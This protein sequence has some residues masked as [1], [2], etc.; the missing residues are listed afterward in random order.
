M[1]TDP[2]GARPSGEIRTRETIAEALRVAHADVLG[3]HDVTLESNLLELGGDSLT[4][5]MVAG[6][7]LEQFPELDDPDLALTLAILEAPTIRD[8]ASTIFSAIRRDATIFATEGRD[9]VSHA[10]V[11]LLPD[12]AW[13]LNAAYFALENPNRWNQAC[14]FQFTTPPDPQILRAAACDV[15]DTHEGL[16]AYFRRSDGVWRQYIQPVSS[17]APF[18]FLAVDSMS[19]EDAVLQLEKLA[20]L[21]QNEL[22]IEQGPL[23][24]FVLCEVGNLP[25][26]L[27]VIAHHLVS[28]NVSYE[29]ILRDLASAYRARITGQT[30]I[31]PTPTPFHLWAEAVSTLAKSPEIKSE[32]SRWLQLP[33]DTLA[34]LPRDTD[35][36]TENIVL[37]T[38]AVRMSLNGDLSA[39]LLRE[40]PEAQ[41]VRTVEIVLAAI[42]KVLTDWAAGPLAIKV[43]DS[44]RSSLATGSLDPAR[45]VGRLATSGV[46]FFDYEDPSSTQ[47]KELAAAI[48]QVRCTP[49]MGI[50]YSLL[51]WVLEQEHFESSIEHR[52]QAEVL[53]NYLGGQELGAARDTAVFQ[54]SGDKTGPREDEHNPRFT[55]FDIGI[56]IADGALTM[57]WSFSESLH[58][59]ATVEDLASRIAVLLSSYA[60]FSGADI[61]VAD[62]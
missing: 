35:R 45:I 48:E 23:I 17:V 61:D 1:S 10:D 46:L 8:L 40:I 62:G 30:P 34:Q 20:D 22:D 6:R 51:R 49:K 29:I 43:V 11:P 54:A 33:W 15:W 9:A 39:A 50:G 25:S 59:V 24:R 31:L 36:K 53:V 47:G 26:R 57:R 13:F 52:W 21:S 44:G 56:Y 27:L 3:L 58:D 38:R 41:G 19:R 16:R 5:I 18:T 14:Y 7:L 12:Q 4:A 42:G 2:E 55:I 60:R 32:M 37:S 28:D